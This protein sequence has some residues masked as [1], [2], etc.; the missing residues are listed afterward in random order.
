MQVIL[1]ILL[2]P[3][4]FIAFLCVCQLPAIL[5]SR[6]ERRSV[7][8]YDD[9]SKVTDEVR[10]IHSDNPYVPPPVASVKNIPIGAYAA[11]QLTQAVRLGF[12]PLASTS[13]QS[14]KLVQVR[15]DFLVSPDCKV[16]AIVS[17]GTVAAIP[18]QTVFMVSQLNNDIVFT[19][20]GAHAACNH[21]LNQKRTEM[22]VFGADFQTMLR[23][24]QRRCEVLGPHVKPFKENE[25]LETLYRSRVQYFRDYESRGLINY[26][27]KDL[28]EWKY[29]WKGAF[30]FVF[31]ATVRQLR[32][33][34]FPDRWLAEPMLTR[35][36][37]LA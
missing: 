24:H 22:L 26:I 15:Y 5:V 28:K 23:Y 17:F 31:Y 32:R 18:V 37:S 9:R 3:L 19:T 11:E 29:T 35:V 14:K 21:D 33:F 1:I 6:F 13:D 36:N 12:R 27:D 30:L 16:I 7:W 25:E 2:L 4:G 8:P 34:V 20:L 10:S